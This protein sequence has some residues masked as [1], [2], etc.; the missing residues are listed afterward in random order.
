MAGGLIGGSGFFGRRGSTG[1]TSTTLTRE[2]AYPNIKDIIIS[3]P[4][5]LF[6]RIVPPT[7]ELPSYSHTKNIPIASPDRRCEESHIHPEVLQ[8]HDRPP[9]RQTMAAA[10]LLRLPRLD[11]EDG[12]VLLN[13]SSGKRPLDLKMIG[14]EGENVYSV[15]GKLR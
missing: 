13:V 1:P 10:T 4:F 2:I 15:S 7:H 14:T 6:S 9:V 12:F 11:E 5:C 3:T 8:F